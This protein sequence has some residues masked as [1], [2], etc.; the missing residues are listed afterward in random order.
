V[1]I[2]SCFAFVR[3][4]HLSEMSAR[5]RDHSPLT[6][7]TVKQSCETMYLHKYLL[8]LCIC[9]YKHILTIQNKDLELRPYKRYTTTT[10]TI[11][12]W[13][14]TTVGFIFKVPELLLGALLYDMPYIAIK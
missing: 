4:T 8:F 13:V 5:T 11:F 1:L 6:G 14:Y 3:E 2:V 7:S 12:S 10:S 9:T